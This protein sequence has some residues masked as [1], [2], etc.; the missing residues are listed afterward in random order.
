MMKLL[1]IGNSFSQDAHRYLHELAKHNGIDLET[2]NLFIG[3]CNLQRHCAC[4]DS[5]EAAYDLELNGGE[6]VRRISLGDALRSDDFDLITVQQSSGDSGRPQTYFPYLEKLVSCCREKQPSA[7]LLFHQTWAYETDSDHKAFIHYGRD[8]AE[9]YRRICDC[10]EMVKKVAG[11]PVIPAG[12]MIQT[13]RNTVPEFDYRKGG[14][15]LCRDGFHLS[16]DYG[17][18]AAAYVWLGCITGENIT[19]KGFGSFS[20]ALTAKIQAAGIPF[21]H[22][23]KG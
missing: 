4:L 7:R 5:G 1:S 16:L 2:V 6:G 18:L 22:R 13:L 15:S 17:R 9:M 19:L 3:G 21:V 20:E 10:T 23:A 12:A 14:I 8:Q 11:I